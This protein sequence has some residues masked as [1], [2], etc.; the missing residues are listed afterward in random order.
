MICSGLALSGFVGRLPLPCVTQRGGYYPRRSVGI[1]ADTFAEPLNRGGKGDRR[2]PLLV[3]GS[4]Q[5]RPLLR[6][7]LSRVARVVME[8]GIASTE[9][10]DERDGVRVS[11][12]RGVELL[13]DLSLVTA[14]HGSDATR[15][16]PPAP[17]QTTAP[18]ICLPIAAR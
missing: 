2:L 17:P 6:R 7:P 14:C 12:R 3:Q 16:T 4:I 13:V 5:R 9:R 10:R 15:S 8:N 18:R 11:L 1:A